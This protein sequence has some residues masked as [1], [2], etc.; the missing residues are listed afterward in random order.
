MTAAFSFVFKFS[1]WYHLIKYRQRR[2]TSHLQQDNS[3]LGLS[4]FQ[5]LNPRRCPRKYWYLSFSSWHYR[6]PC[7]ISETW[8]DLNPEPP[9]FLLSI[10]P[11][12]I[13]S[14]WG[15]SPPKYPRGFGSKQRAAPDDGWAP[16]RPSVEG[17]PRQG[18]PTAPKRSGNLARKRTSICREIF[19]S[20]PNIYIA[21]Q[22]KSCWP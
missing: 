15:Q 6:K 9:S 14:S 17:R 18:A 12:Q 2:T 3:H 1:P 13:S 16:T 5:A 8:P 10:L 4:P 19:W 11:L 20:F 22:I 21:T 7:K